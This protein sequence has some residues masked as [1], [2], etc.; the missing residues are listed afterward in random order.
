[1]VCYYPPTNFVNY[2]DKNTNWFDFLPVRNVS[3]N[4]S[5]VATPGSPREIQNKVLRSISPYFFISE[6]APPVCIMHGTADDLVP[7]SQS[8][9]FIARLMEYDI[10]SLLVP[11]EGKGH[12]WQTDSTDYAAFSKWFDTYLLKQ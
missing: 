4:G 3:T 12:G 5:F 8:V 6:H 9:A 11:R 10:P 1:V 2:V 7:F